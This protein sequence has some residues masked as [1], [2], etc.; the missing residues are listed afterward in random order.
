METTKI[1]ISDLV[2]R[3]RRAIKS[4]G[5]K[6]KDFAAKLDVC[7]AHLSA[8]LNGHETLTAKTIDLIALHTGVNR[9]WILTGEGDMFALAPVSL[10]APASVPAIPLPAADPML[11]R[12][13]ELN[14][15]IQAACTIWKDL[16][17]VERHRL[18]A[19][20]MADL[21]KK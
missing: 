4:T 8:V 13:P 19:Q 7:P 9:D 18:A 3:A 11:D 6:Q 20:M 10:V 2:V 15:V 21:N 1:D 14:H 12:F 17:P 5:V 16:D